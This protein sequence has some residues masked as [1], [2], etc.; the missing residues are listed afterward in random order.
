MRYLIV[1]ALLLT[2]VPALAQFW[3]H[4]ANERFGYELDIPPG[5]S[6]YSEASEGVAQHFFMAGERQEL[7][8][9]GGRLESGLE[10]FTA[11]LIIEHTA[12]G[13]NTTSQ[14][15]TPQWA[16]LSGVQPKRSF[17]QR[18]ILL[19]DGDSYA[20]FRLEFDTADLNAVEPILQGLT[21]SFVPRGC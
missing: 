15:A 1:F 6:S 12:N 2:T 13:W 5:F 19:C 4:Y 18:M 17:F 9:W 7:K 14:S 16:S 8:L 10:H 21:R 3:T 11:S 20:A